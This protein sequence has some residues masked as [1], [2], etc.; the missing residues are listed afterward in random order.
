MNGCK[1]AVTV[2]FD[3]FR[4]MPTTFVYDQDYFFQAAEIDFQIG[5]HDDL[6]IIMDLEKSH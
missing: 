2:R 5:E 6:L 1:L 3:V 4:M